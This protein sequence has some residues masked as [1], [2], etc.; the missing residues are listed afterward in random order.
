MHFPRGLCVPG[1][2]RVKSSVHQH[3]GK[4]NEIKCYAYKA[5]EVIISAIQYTYMRKYFAVDHSLS[6]IEVTEVHRAGFHVGEALLP[7]MSDG[8]VH[9]VVA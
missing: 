5:N 9:P 8:V 2:G 3:S 7:R 6:C 4:H 1:I